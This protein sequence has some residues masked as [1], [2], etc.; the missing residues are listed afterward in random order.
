MKNKVITL[1]IAICFVCTNVYAQGIVITKSDSS[2]IYYSAEEIISIS[3]YGY[4]EEPQQQK[5]CIA[6]GDIKN[7][8]PTSVTIFNNIVKNVPSYFK[9]GV[10]FS[11]SNNLY[12]DGEMMFTTNSKDSISIDLK[13]LEPETEYFY[14][15]F[16]EGDGFIHYGSTKMFKTPEI[17]VEFSIETKEATN[18]KQNE[19]TLNGN[20]TPKGNFTSIDDLEPFTIGFLINTSDSI[21]IENNIMNVKIDNA[22]FNG[23]KCITGLNSNTKYYYKMYIC[24]D[25][26]YYFG[27]TYTFKTTY[28]IGDAYP[29]Q[30]DSIGIVFFVSNNGNNGL[31]FSL[32][33]TKLEWEAAYNWCKD[34]GNG[35]YLPNLNNLR[36]LS[37]VISQFQKYHPNGMY[38]SSDKDEETSNKSQYTTYYYFKTLGS[39]AGFGNGYTDSR[40]TSQRLNV[41]AVKE[42]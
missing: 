39:Y 41:I 16:T 1:L 20:F 21:S 2:K 25:G 15:A 38:W 33:H 3:S 14:G 35:W 22:K 12:I 40:G 7:L 6:T 27:E 5:F 42:F 11:K 24:Y 29:T 26:N 10:I 18:I 23:Y 4:G 19:A 36:K 17:K 34:K 8:T 9:R 31:I 32:D 30:E 28:A 13:G 37:N